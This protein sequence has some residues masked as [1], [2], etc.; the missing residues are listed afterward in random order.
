LNITCSQTTPSANITVTSATPVTFSWTP[1]SGIL[2]STT[3]STAIFNSANTYTCIITSTTGCKSNA[4]VTVS[5]STT[6]PSIVPGTATAQAISCTNS[7]VTI[8]PIFTPSAN[9]TYTWSG[10]NILGATNASSVNVS[11][12]GTYSLAVSNPTNG[13]I[14]NTITVVVVSLNG[15]PVFTVTSSSSVGISCSPS[16]SIVSLTAITNSVGYSYLWSTGAT[17]NSI[18]TTTG[19]NYSVTVT[20]TLNGCSSIQI[21]NVPNSSISPNLTTASLVQLPC[22][23]GTTTIN[24]SSTDNNIIYSWLGAGIINGVNTPTAVINAPGIYTVIATNSITNCKSTQTI[25]ANSNSVVA[26]FTANTISGNQPLNVNFNNTSVG[27][28]SYTWSF[29]NNQPTSNETNPNYSFS[30]GVYTV[31]LAAQKSNCISTATLEIVVLQGNI[32][33]PEIFTPNG[34]AYN[35]FF[36]IKGLNSYP[37]ATL[38]VFNRWGN[39][40]YEATPYENNWDGTPNQNSLGKDKLPSSTYYYILDLH[41]TEFKPF[42]GFV[43]ITY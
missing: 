14:N 28:T 38:Q 15:P 27:A 1:A 29:V 42:I 3:G 35:Q 9:L 33:I 8:A 36:E 30:S 7:V 4:I 41:V 17:S 11:Q 34:D 23:G 39:L 26:S 20:N 21:I 43:H 40:V 25:T 5:S 32:K 37:K 2:G 24:A 19:G 6:V 12:A 13:C 16:N 18:S 10:G 22:N 31:V